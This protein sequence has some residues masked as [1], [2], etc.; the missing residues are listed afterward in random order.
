MDMTQKL[1]AALIAALL[2]CAGAGLAAAQDQPS[3]SN[4]PAAGSD[5]NTPE[6]GQ[7]KSM[8]GGMK[9]HGMD[10]CK[11]DVAKFC[12]DAKTH[13]AKHACLEKHEDELS[14]ACKKHHEAMEKRWK[15]GH[16]GMKGHDEKMEKGE[17]Q[18]SNP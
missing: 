7:K 17:T 1:S 4:P 3:S 9:E 6:M 16:K 8:K 2:M 11:D 12:A 18:P 15:K 14:P 13:K 5:M 10:A